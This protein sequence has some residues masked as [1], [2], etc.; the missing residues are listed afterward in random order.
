MIKSLNSVIAVLLLIVLS[1][2]VLFT[3]VSAATAAQ[4][5]IRTV[6]SEGGTYTDKTAFTVGEKIYLPIKFS[7]IGSVGVQ[8]FSCEI[9]F[10]ADVLTFSEST[11]VAINDENAVFDK[12]VLDSTIYL[13]WD[14]TSKNIVF[15]SDAIF[16]VFETKE[17]TEDADISFTIKINDFYSS[18]SGKPDIA[19]NIVNQTVT[20]SIAAH[21]IDEAVLA[22]LKKLENITT[23]SLADIVAAETAWNTLSEKQKQFLKTNHKNEYDWL[24]TARTRLN[25]AINQANIAAVNKLLNEFKT[26][27]KTVLELTSETVKVENKSAVKAALTAYKTLPTSVTTRLDQTIPTRLQDLLDKI[28]ILEDSEKEA[29]SFE[30]SY[31]YLT[32][33]NDTMLET[34]F[35]AYSGFI[36]EAIMV[37][38]LL[39]DEAKVAV[40]ETYKKLQALKKKCDD[41]VAKDEALAAIRNEVNAFQ[42]KWLQ[43]FTVNTGNVTVYDKTAIELVIADYEKNLSEKAKESLAS[44]IATFKSLLIAIEELESAEDEESETPSEQ[45]PDDNSGTQSGGSAQQQPD[46]NSSIQQPQTQPTPEVLT[47]V[48][49]EIQVQEKIVEKEVLNT[50]YLNKNISKTIWILLVLLVI[51]VLTLVFPAYMTIRYRKRRLALGEEMDEEDEI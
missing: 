26:T 44:R 47:E 28:E 8:G 42:Q 33:L 12:N 35:D 18:E 25:E 14:T 13:I 16:V 29:K 4:I 39:P 41:I 24:N 1:F 3:P 49:T 5:Q 22:A 43:V 32:E 10:N 2:T 51:S 27:H 19:Y 23:D 9:T 31:G 38:D 21:K 40:S 46:N 48:K 36:D 45:Q 30:E 7:G 20:A 34:S 50:K 37:Y 17:L 11:F 15:N 6:G